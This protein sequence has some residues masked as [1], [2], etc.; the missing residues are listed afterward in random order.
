[1]ILA[2]FGPLGALPLGPHWGHV[3]YMNN[4]E[5]PA[6][7]DDSCQIWLKSNHGVFKMMMKYCIRHIFRESNFSR[8]GTVRHFRE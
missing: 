6:P 3:P 2:W 1:M 4:Y 5:S 7:K 8:I